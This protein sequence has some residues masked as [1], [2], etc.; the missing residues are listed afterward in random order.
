[1]AGIFTISPVNSLSFVRANSLLSNFDNTV[2]QDLVK[3]LSKVPYCQKVQKND[4]L[5]IQIKTDFTTITAQLYDVVNNSFTSLTPSEETTYD[6]FSFW[7]IPILFDT[8]GYYKV[9]ISGGLSGYETVNLE[10]EMIEAADSWDG[11]KIEA[12]NDDNTPFVD[13]STGITHVFRVLGQVRF[14]DIGGKEE[15]YNNFGVEQRIYSENEMID[16]L[17]VENIPYYLGKQLI[18]CSKLDVLKINDLD[19]IGKDH[20]LAPH[21]GSHNYDLVIKLSRKSV[22]GV[23]ADY[24]S[25]TV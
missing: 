2:Y 4:T 25:A 10:S 17:T 19:Y 6:D 11:V 1:M 23:N 5:T 14:S 3:D 18:F 16:E 9:F 8:N 13:Y 12:Y 7:E 21:P 24:Q 15:F 20:N 22:P